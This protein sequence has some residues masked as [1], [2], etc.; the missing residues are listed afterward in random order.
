MSAKIVSK[1]ISMGS[2]VEIALVNV[3]D[4][5]VNS[6]NPNLMRDDKFKILK[7]KIAESGVV[8]QPILVFRNEDGTCTVTDGEHRFLAAKEGA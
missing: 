6:W 8:T 5:S 2:G 3:S 7:S 1:K 4:V